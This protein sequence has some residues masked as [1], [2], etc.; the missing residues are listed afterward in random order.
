M[1]KGSSETSNVGA[2]RSVVL[3]IGARATKAGSKGAEENMVGT[4]RGIQG[5]VGKWRCIH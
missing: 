3:Q 5:D 4:C 2:V 1:P